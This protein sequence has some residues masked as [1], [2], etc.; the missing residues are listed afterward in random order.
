VTKT[1]SAAIALSLL[2]TAPAFAANAERSF[3][4]DGVTYTYVAH[5]RGDSVVL[6]GRAFPKGSAFRLVVRGDLVRGVSG[7]VPVAFKVQKPLAGSIQ[8]AAR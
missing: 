6:K 4:R 8:T 1:F 3:T 7:G 2:A 5:H